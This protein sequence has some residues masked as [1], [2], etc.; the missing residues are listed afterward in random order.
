MIYGAYHCDLTSLPYN[1]QVEKRR[2]SLLSNLVRGA[3]RVA[4]GKEPVES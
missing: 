4:E 3:K 1:E 2:F